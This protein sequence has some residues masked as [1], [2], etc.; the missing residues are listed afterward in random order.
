MSASSRQASPTSPA[1]VS[2]GTG[3]SAAKIA[4]SAR[5]IHSRQRIPS[6]KS[7]K[8]AVETGGAGAA[9]RP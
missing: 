5:I 7:D 1:S 4:A 3:F 6:G 2:R 9:H 8:V